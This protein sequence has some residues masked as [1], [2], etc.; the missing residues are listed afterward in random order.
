MTQAQAGALVIDLLRHGETE[1][2]ARI[3]GSIDDALTVTGW[4]QMQ[5]ATEGGQWHRVVTSPLARCAAFARALARERHLPCHV[6]ESWREV[7]F[8][9]WEGRTAAELMVRDSLALAR[10]WQDPGRHPPPGA[11]PLDAFEARVQAAFRDVL[12][13]RH[14]E[15]VLIV[16]HGGVIRCLLGSA[17]GLAYPRL[18]ELPVGHGSLHRLD[19]STDGAITVAGAG[20]AG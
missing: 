17:L 19:I 20:V 11:E 2:G 7:H 9:A 18:F 12:A 15:R 10:F 1:G 4:Q 16:T 6:E 13:Q 3:R 14:G 8:G 5:Q